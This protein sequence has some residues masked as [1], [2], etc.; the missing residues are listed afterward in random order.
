[1]T[2]VL[3]TSAAS[4]V[5][6]GELLRKLA[7]LREYAGRA[8]ERRPAEAAT[9]AADPPLEDALAMSLLVAIRQAVDICFYVVSVEARIAWAR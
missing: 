1:M 9:L 6:H 8:R 5:M 7:L 3:D 2:L 4:A